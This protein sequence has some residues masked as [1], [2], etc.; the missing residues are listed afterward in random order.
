MI[1]PCTTAAKTVDALIGATAVR[2]AEAVAVRWGGGMRRESV[3]AR[4]ETGLSELT[5][6]ELDAIS[7]RVAAQLVERGIKGGA[8]VGLCLQRGVEQLV[9]LLGILR[10]GAAV[11]PLDA[12]DRKSVV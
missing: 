1:E 9:A 8:V 4:E 12:G 3:G 6:G 2:A 5:Y 7:G 10:A 11:L